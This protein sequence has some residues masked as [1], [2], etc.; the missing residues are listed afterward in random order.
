MNEK[1]LMRQ[2]ESII[3]KMDTGDGFVCAWPTEEEL[4]A[5]IKLVRDSTPVE[6]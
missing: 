5:I 6:D 1:E 2:I 4:T 3:Q